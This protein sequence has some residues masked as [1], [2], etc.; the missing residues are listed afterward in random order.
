MGD[1]SRIQWTEATWNPVTGCTKVS[2]GCKHCYAET[3]AERFRGTPQFPVGFDIQIRPER[4]D[5]PVRWKRP[6]RI[7]VNSMSDLFHE[8]IPIETILQLMEVMRA[9]PRHTYQILTKRPHRA[10]E[11][12]K[13]MDGTWPANAWLGTSVENQQTAVRLEYLLMLSK[14]PIV[15]ASFEPLLGPVD[16]HLVASNRA[17]NWAIIG[18]ESGAHA[19]EMK[20]HW[21]LD[22]LNDCMDMRIHVFF[23]QAGEVLARKWGCMDRKGGDL[24][25]I[26][27]PFRVREYPE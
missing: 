15:F 14:V 23:K 10:L 17:L 11:I 1:R 25:E 9:T 12:E 27:E 16:L 5:Q 6:R 8:Q 3:I 4:F 13:L 7:F 22:L 21:A 24:S 2:A 20:P 18:G 19:R 26:P